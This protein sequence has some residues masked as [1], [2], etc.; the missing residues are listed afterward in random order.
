MAV[1]ALNACESNFSNVNFTLFSRKTVLDSI[2][3]YIVNV[4]KNNAKLLCGKWSLKRC[5]FYTIIFS[6]LLMTSKNKYLIRDSKLTL[7]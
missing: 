1:H 6:K 4:V 5:D 2:E 7:V 3:I